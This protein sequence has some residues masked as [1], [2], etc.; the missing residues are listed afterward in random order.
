VAE[1]AEWRER[2]RIGDRGERVRDCMLQRKGLAS[3]I[4]LTVGQL[5]HGLETDNLLE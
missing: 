3:V 2:E 1:T 5:S 4:N